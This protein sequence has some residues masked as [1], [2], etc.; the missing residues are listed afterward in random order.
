MTLIEQLK[1]IPDPRKIKGR[2]HPWRMI[3]FLSLLGFLCGYRGYRPLA[4]FCWHHQ[5]SLVICWTYP[6]GKRCR[7]I[8]PFGTV[9]CK[10]SLRDGLR[11]LISGHWQP[12]PKRGECH[13]TGLSSGTQI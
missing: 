5:S 2:R 13:R 7:P 1:Q 6:I 9:F 8:R 12:C 10:S 11:R 3:L 4:D